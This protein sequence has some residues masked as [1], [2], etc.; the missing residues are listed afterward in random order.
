MNSTPAKCVQTLKM[1]KKE[2]SNSLKRVLTC[3]SIKAQAVLFEYNIEMAETNIL[4]NYRKA[5]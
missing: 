1:E 2:L 3:S 4:P 5:K